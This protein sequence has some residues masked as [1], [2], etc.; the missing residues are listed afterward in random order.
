MDGKKNPWRVIVRV[1]SYG[2][3]SSYEGECDASQFVGSAKALSRAAT[4]T[5]TLCYRV[6]VA[7]MS[8]AAAPGKESTRQRDASL[9]NWEQLVSNVLAEMSSRSLQTP[10]P[11][12]ETHAAGS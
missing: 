2:G 11:S 4:E 7:D 9:S 12:S 10:D 5:E 8:F 3:F 6:S 1:P